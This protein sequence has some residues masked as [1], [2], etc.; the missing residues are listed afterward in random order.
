MTD[1]LA[2]VRDGRTILIAF[3]VILV[4]YFSKWLAARVTALI[5]R[6]SRAEFWTA[7]GLSHA[8]AAVTIPTLVIGLQAGLFDSSLF[9]AS[10]LMILMT[11][12][13]SPLLVQRFAPG[14]HQENEEDKESLLFE[15]ILVPIANPQTQENLL[16]LAS[17]LARANGGRVLALNVAQEVSGKVM[18]LEHQRELLERV[19]QILGDP[20]TPIDLLPRISKSYANGILHAALEQKAS[21]MLMGWRGKRT[22]QQSI[23]GTVLDEVI[24]GSDLPVMVGKLSQTMNSIQRVLLILP[25]EALAPNVVRRML[26]AN[27]ALARAMNV[28]MKILSHSSYQRQ[29]SHWVQGRDDDQVFVIEEYKGSLKLGDVEAH[30]KSDFL[31]IPGFGSRKRFLASVGNLPEQLASIYEGNLV[32]LHFDH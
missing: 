13:T 19:P 8:Q 3:G 11:S 26:E 4:A 30:E 5:F 22:L 25:Y 9:N 31:V 2:F 6:Y 24:W 14:I 32:I 23:L 27:L 17:L 10:I 29:V 1:P 12:I 15:R 18:G 21:I 16:A 28:P 20:D 7:F